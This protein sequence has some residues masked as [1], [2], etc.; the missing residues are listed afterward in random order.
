MTKEFFIYES[1]RS[2]LEPVETNFKS[3]NFESNDRGRLP[4]F[5][6]LTDAEIINRNNLHDFNWTP[7]FSW[8]LNKNLEAI[9]LNRYIIWCL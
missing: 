6:P 3:V 8:F 9:F 2:K 4:T 5:F 1:K 7:S